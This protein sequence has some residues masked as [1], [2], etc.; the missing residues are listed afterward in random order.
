MTDRIAEI[1]AKLA[2]H[3]AKGDYDVDLWPV[4]ALAACEEKDE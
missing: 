1:E 3:I 2:A 4:K